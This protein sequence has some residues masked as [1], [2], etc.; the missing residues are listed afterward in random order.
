MNKKNLSL[1]NYPTSFTRRIQF[2]SSFK[3]EL[4][5]Q[6]LSPIKEEIIFPD[7]FQETEFNVSLIGSE[8]LHSQSNFLTN[9]G[10]QCFT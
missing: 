5:F 3:E 8:K 2:A 4:P 7:S 10:K 6:N 1:E 9:L